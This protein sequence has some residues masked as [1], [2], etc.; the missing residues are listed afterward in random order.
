MLGVFQENTKNL[1]SKK[2]RIGGAS[3]ALCSAEIFRHK[4]SI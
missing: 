3:E 1:T 4:A 2:N